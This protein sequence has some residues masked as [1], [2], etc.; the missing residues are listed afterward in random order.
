VLGKCGSFDGFALSAWDSLCPPVK[1]AEINIKYRIPVRNFRAL[2][3][4][5]GLLKLND[6]RW[7]GIVI[8][9]VAH[10]ITLQPRRDEPEVESRASGDNQ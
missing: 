5:L 6:R 8:P 2:L 3:W 7:R 9:S 10:G 1:L 4:V